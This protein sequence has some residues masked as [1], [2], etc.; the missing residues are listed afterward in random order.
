MRTVGEL[1]EG[2]VRT[3]GG[4]P[5]LR[6]KQDGEWRTATWADYG[7]RARRVARALIAL[8]VEPRRGV[9]IMSYNRP[10][11]LLA[12]LGAILAG[13]I[14]TGIYTTSAREQVTYIARHCEA[15]VVVVENATYL[16]IFESLRAELPHL[17]AIVVIAGVESHGDVLSWADFEARGD[18]VPETA[19]DGR[20]AAQ[21]ENDPCTLIYTSGTTGAPKA[22]MISHRNV[23]FLAEVAGPAYGIGPADRFLSYLPLS[24]IAEQ[25]V[26]VYMP[27]MG[28]SCSYFAESLEKLPEN[29][30]EVRPTI[31]F[32]VPRVWEKIQARMQAVGAAAPWLRRKIAAWAR[33]KGLAG[34]YAAQRGGAGPAG[35]ALAEKVVFSKVKERLGLDAARICITSAAPISLGTLEYFLSLGITICEVYGM[36]E[37]TG[38]TTFSLPDRVRTGRAGFA[39]PGTELRIAEDG[40]VLMRGEHVFLGYYKDEAATREALDAEG[41]LHSG[42]IG[43]LDADG[44]LRITDRKK[45]LIIT[46]GGKNVAPA[47]IEARLKTIPGIAQA[48]LVG[49]QRNYVA[50]LFTLD[51]ERVAEVAR[52]HGSPARDIAAARDCAIFRAYLERELERL[53]ATLARYEMVRRFVVLPGELTVDGGELTPTMKLKRRVIREKYAAEIESLYT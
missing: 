52:Q 41:W 25:C 11:W 6:W 13:A 5:A 20:L 53:S 36:S 14:P 19:L 2:T 7:A 28:G 39:I 51:P 40:E 43:D 37:C 16:E 10:E 33:A 12:D 22:V 9:A 47:P 29:L 21:G 27:M 38:P 24:H 44:F 3:H 49:D 4:R 8:G 32:G 46:S 26:S 35:F 17:K 48:V 1:F 45:E 42:D 15:A 31:F 30:R 18:A 23:T 34:G 50:A